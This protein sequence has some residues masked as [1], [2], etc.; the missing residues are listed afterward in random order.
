MTPF[1]CFCSPSPTRELGTD[2]RSRTRTIP[3]SCQ[4]L[5][6]PFVINPSLFFFCYW[7]SLRRVQPNIYYIVEIL[8]F[9]SLAHFS[10]L[11]KTLWFPFPLTPKPIKLKFWSLLGLFHIGKLTTHC[12][13]NYSAIAIPDQSP[14][15]TLHS[16]IILGNLVRILIIPKEGTFNSRTGSHSIA[17]HQWLGWSPALGDNP[18]QS[19]PRREGEG[20]CQA[21]EGWCWISTSSKIEAKERHTPWLHVEKMFFQLAFNL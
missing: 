8:Y 17:A 3:L 19:K 20:W 5:Q 11:T 14:L 1:C 12:R 2:P 7:I 13:I 10:S 18:D 15:W 9:N 6:P 16:R 4:L 21:W